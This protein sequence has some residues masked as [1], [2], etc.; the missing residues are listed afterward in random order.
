MEK[1]QP[2][3]AQEQDKS[4][5]QII[6]ELLKSNEENPTADARFNAF[7]DDA[8]TLAKALASDM[9][10]MER[11]KQMLASLQDSCIGKK[12]A[13]QMSRDTLIKWYDDYVRVDPPSETLVETPEKAEPV[14]H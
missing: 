10:S 9:I 2:L 5:A 14:S 7:L 12:G 13:L 3:E 11:A 8:R 4:T 1:G 6:D